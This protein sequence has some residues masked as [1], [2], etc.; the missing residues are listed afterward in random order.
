[1]PRTLPR[2]LTLCNHPFDFALL[3][4]TQAVESGADIVLH[5]VLQPAQDHS[6]AKAARIVGDKLPVRFG[7]IAACKQ[8]IDIRRHDMVADAPLIVLINVPVHRAVNMQNSLPVRLR[9]TDCSIQACLDGFHRWMRLDDL[10]GIFTDDRFYKLGEILIV[11]VKRVA[12]D[13]TGFGN[14]ADG[15]FAERFLV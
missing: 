12:V 15:D 9:K 13:P 2:F 10:L 7:Y 14:A 8:T 3:E 1:M 6:K 5:A 4:C 11:V